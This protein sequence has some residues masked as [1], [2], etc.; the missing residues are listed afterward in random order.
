MLKVKLDMY[1]N[2]TC[3]RQLINLST[4]V[5]L[6]NELGFYLISQPCGPVENRNNYNVCSFHIRKTQFMMLN[7]A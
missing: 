5:L 3:T 1:V 7:I 2:L 4:S 6:K